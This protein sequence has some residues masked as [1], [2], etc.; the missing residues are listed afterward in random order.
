MPSDCIFCR[1]A[2]GREPAFIVYEDAQFL[3]FL[4]KY[5]QSPGHLQLIPK[6]HVRWIYDL[7]EMGT[8][9]SVAQ[10]I[11]RAIIPVLSADH[12]SVGTFG[13]EVHHA[14]IWIVPQ[15]GRD[16]KISEGSGRPIEEDRVK[17]MQKLRAVLSKEVSK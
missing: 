3:A 8:I 7:P 17:M 14:H 9:F 10:R 5:P 6:T 11:I 12:I 15:Y 4:D 1:I 13:R 16:R 2:A